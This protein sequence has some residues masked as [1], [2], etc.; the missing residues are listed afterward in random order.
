MY[1]FKNKSGINATNNSAVLHPTSG[2]RARNTL[3]QLAANLR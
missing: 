2:Y 1:K 3:S